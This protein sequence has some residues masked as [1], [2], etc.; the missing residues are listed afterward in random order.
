MSE[1]LIGL[2]QQSIDP[3]QHQQAEAQL[4]QAESTPGFSITLLQI[5]GNPENEQTVRL[6][7]ALCFKNLVRRKWTNDQGDHLLPSNEIIQIKADIVGLMISCPPNLQAQLGEAISEIA[8]CDFYKQWDTLVDV[9][10]LN[11]L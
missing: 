10:T 8:N 9:C 2:L 3:R 6:A 4:K 11:I 1:G 5:V 7:A